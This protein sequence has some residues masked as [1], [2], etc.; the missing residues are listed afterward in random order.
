M[1]PQ[2]NNMLQVF[3]V[4]RESSLRVDLYRGQRE[5]EMY[6]AENQFSWA[7]LQLVFAENNTF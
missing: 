4:C 2:I 1:V 3:H 5:A 6:G 7:Y